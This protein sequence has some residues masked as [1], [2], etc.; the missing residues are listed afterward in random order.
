VIMDQSNKKRR[1]FF[2]VAGGFFIIASIVGFFSG[3]AVFN[4]QDTAIFIGESYNY[5]P[6][7]RICPIL[8]AKKKLWIIPLLV[9]YRTEKA[10]YVLEIRVTSP[11]PPTSEI[12]EYF[13]VKE[14][15]YSTERL[16][17]VNMRVTDQWR[18]G[19]FEEYAGGST[20]SF[21]LSEPLDI[22]A[23]KD[24]KVNIDVIIISYKSGN[25]KELHVQETLTAWTKKGFIPL[26]DALYE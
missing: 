25:P 5:A 4:Y 20:A 1:I 14:F 8:H 13:V 16:G 9:A 15:N 23:K 18:S 17:L 26:S 24:A 7:G 21:F 2:G 10:P 19:P 11:V 3:C 12:D 6:L 22:D